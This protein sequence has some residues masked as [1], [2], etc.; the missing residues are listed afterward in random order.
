VFSSDLCQVW[1]SV[2]SVGNPP[3]NNRIQK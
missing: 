1:M 2:M 3:L